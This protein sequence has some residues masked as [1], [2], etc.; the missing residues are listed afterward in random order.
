MPP[1]ES[2]MQHDPAQL[3]LMA[4]W[5]FEWHKIASGQNCPRDFWRRPLCPVRKVPVS[6]QQSH[7]RRLLD[8]MDGQDPARFPHR[9]F[10]KRKRSGGVGLAYGRQANR[11]A[12]VM[13]LPLLLL[14]IRGESYALRKIGFAISP[15]ATLLNTS[16]MVRV[17]AVKAARTLNYVARLS[18]GRITSQPSE[19]QV[20]THCPGQG[21]RSSS[22]RPGGYLPAPGCPAFPGSR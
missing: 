18:P 4:R 19:Q 5:C 7:H 9:P 17:R 14:D 8:N 15:F 21:F 20:P 10:P 1:V 12:R 13:P 3:T 6:G 11:S 16:Y 2:F 22:L